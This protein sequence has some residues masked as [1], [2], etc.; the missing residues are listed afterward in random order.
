MLI[1]KSDVA[2]DSDDFDLDLEDDVNEE[3]LQKIV[4]E[5][6]NKTSAGDL[7]VCVKLQLQNIL[8]NF[9]FYLTGFHR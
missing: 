2:D 9:T 6:K 8:S 1:N 5:I 4:Q 3:E 7:Q